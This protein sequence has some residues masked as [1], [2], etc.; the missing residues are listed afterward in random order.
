MLVIKIKTAVADI[1]DKT[2]QEQTEAEES[3]GQCLSVKEVSEG[4]KERK[5]NQGKIGHNRP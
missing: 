3:R 1:R 4:V 5:I 2:I